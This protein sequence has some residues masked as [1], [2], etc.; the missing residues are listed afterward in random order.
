MKIKIRKKINTFTS[1]VVKKNKKIGKV[2]KFLYRFERSIRYLRFKY[3]NRINDKQII[4]DSYQSRSYACSPKEIYLRMIKDPR[5][6]DYTFI[7]CFRDTDKKIDMTKNTKIVRYTSKEYYKA[8]A[9]SKYW[10]VNSLVPEQ[11]KPKRGQVFVQCWHGTPLKRLRCDIEYDGLLNDVKDIRIRND[12][13]A[14]RFTYFISPS[15]FCTDKFTSAFNLK[16]LHKENIFIEKGYPRNDFLFS[17]TDKDVA[18]IKKELNIKKDKKIIL[19]APTFRDNQHT[20]GVGYTYNLGI[21]LDKLMEELKDEYIILFRAHYFVSN[22]IDFEKYKGFVYDVSNYDDVS[23]L[24]V[25][26]DLLITDYSSV[27]FDYAN[28]NRPILFYMYDLD[29]YQNKLRDFYFSLDILPGPILKTEK[30]L[31]KE[32]KKT[33]TI[34]KNYKEKYEK[35]NKKFNYLNDSES[36]LRVINT[37]F[38]ER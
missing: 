8:Y 19:Y 14:K 31:I 35:F 17:Y 11:I 32:I 34:S 5:F 2:I 24:Y 1:N 30:D 16:K 18:K 4:F 25:I 6:K 20:S 33:K 36:S 38:K 21:D 9:S 22:S 10:I 29:E 15:K 26:S 23:R 13:D 3:C 28:L 37:I 12:I 27:F 7:W